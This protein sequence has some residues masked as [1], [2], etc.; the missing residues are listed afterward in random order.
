MG[1]TG[2]QAILAIIQSDD[3]KA[4][5]DGLTLLHLPCLMQIASSGGFLRQSNTALLMAVRAEQ[6]GPVLQVL[7]RTCHLRLDSI[8]SYYAEESAMILTLPLEVEVGG[9]TVFICDVEH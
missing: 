5:L 7:Q 1:I 4:A 6:V 2:M 9:A 8:P 3:T